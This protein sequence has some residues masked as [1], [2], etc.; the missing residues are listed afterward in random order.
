MASGKKAVVEQSRKPT[1]KR[2][3][4]GKGGHRTWFRGEHTNFN[5]DVATLSSPEAIAE[6][7]LKG[8]L[9]A[10]PAVDHGTRITAFGSCF[11]ENISTWLFK[12][13]FNVL[14]KSDPA[15]S[16]YVVRMGEG[17]VNSF[18]IRQQFEWAWENKVFEEQLWHGYDAEEYGYDEQVRLETKAIFD[19]T[20]VFIL[21]FGL[22]EVWYDEP[23]GNVF[24]RTVPRDR[25]DPK[26]HKFRVSTVEENRDNIL[27]IHELIRKYR[28]D[29]KTI[30]TL[31]PI[32]LIATFRNAGC[33]TANSVSK[34]TLRVAI[35]QA[36]SA[37]GADREVYYWPSYELVTD[38]FHLPYKP[39]RRHVRGEVI[40]YILKLFEATWCSDSQIGDNDLLE[41]FVKAQVAARSLPPELEVI[42]AKRRPWRLREFLAE[43]R[44]SP[45][46]AVADAQRDTLKRLLAIW[47]HER[48]EQEALHRVESENSDAS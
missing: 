30:I 16:A 45:D 33:L 43:R 21:T 2:H 48:I 6:F 29:A 3:G 34:A 8:W 31:S 46:P 22:S 36:M 28:P 27:A 4:R 12:R 14:N 32:P 18:V 9:P 7:V 37:A 39:D 20:D 11:A 40:E 13:N 25:Y 42:L 44:I 24:W 17:M 5:P 19:T 23:T 47:R 41:A 10:A 26:R 38:V 15:S 1:I 35:D